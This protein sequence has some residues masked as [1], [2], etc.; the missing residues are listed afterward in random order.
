MKYLFL[1]FLFI[2]I[3]FF[4]QEKKDAFNLLL[5]VGLTPS[6]VHGD[7]FS[8]FHK[9]GFTGGLGVESVFSDKAKMSLSFIFIQKGA[10]K[11]QNPTKGDLTFY[12]L[13]LNYLEVPLMVTYTQSKKYIFDIGV[14]AGYLINS[15]EATENGSF[16][17]LYPFKKME[18][19]VKIGLGYNINS[20]WFANFRSSNSFITTRP[21]YTKQAIYFNNI[22]ARTFNKGYYN[23]ILEFTLGYRIFTKKQN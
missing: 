13:N 6:Q 8:G 15:Y 4:S 20:K 12:Y 22:L 17:N 7:A 21:N 23:N 3:F 5:N 19:S 2:Q 10:R 16:G 14:S 9:V 1:S 18:Y 11:N